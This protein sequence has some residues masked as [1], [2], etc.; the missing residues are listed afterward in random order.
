[1][2]VTDDISALIGQTPLFRLRRLF[3]E[4][5]AP[6]LGKLEMFN[7]MSVKDRP[8]KYIID[9]AVADGRIQPGTELVEASSGNTAIAMALIGATRDLPVR[10][11][12]SDLCSVER[13]QILNAFGATVVLTP[14]VEHTKGARSRAIAY[15]DARP[16]TTF[17]LNQH[18]TPENADAH[19]HT[20]GPEIWEQTNGNVG[21][22]IIGLG[23]SGT[24]EGLS[25]YFKEKEPTIRIIAFE[26]ASSPVYGGGEMGK[27]KL[28]GIGPGF[29]T[30]NFKRGQ[31]R[32]DEL[33]QVS[34]Q[35]AFEMTR[36]LATTEGIL[37]GVTSGA[38]LC[39]A[40]QLAEEP[41]YA[42][43]SIVC[44]LYDSGERY[45]SV[46]GLFPADKVERQD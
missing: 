7:P 18:S 5:T 38:A 45:L 39:V 6:V 42:G 41:T 29:V 33:I 10:I 15:C 40:Q 14:G 4:N 21:A 22:V 13:I 11:F 12:M 34:D 43:R 20:T 24:F 26:P 32:V 16:G 36:L 44:L 46:E 27:H 3:P 25:R 35:D 37:A 23:T 28:I 17:F 19:Y 30:D 1:M 9:K 8:V 2:K 31:D